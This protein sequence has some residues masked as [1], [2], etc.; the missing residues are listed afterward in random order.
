[1]FKSNRCTWIW[2]TMPLINPYSGPFRIDHDI[3]WMALV[4]SWFECQEC[5]G[6]LRFQNLGSWFPPTCQMTQTAYLLILKYVKSY[7]KPVTIILHRLTKNQSF[8]SRF[9]WFMLHRDHTNVRNKGYLLS[10]KFNICSFFFSCLI[11]H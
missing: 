6:F 9:K 2:Q 1:M 3:V 10:K 4:W 11:S 8:Q 5:D 7:L